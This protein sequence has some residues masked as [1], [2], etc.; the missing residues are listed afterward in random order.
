MIRPVLLRFCALSL[1]LSFV[2]LTASPVPAAGNAAGNAAAPE[3]QKKI[4]NAETFT[5][6]NGLQVVVIPNHRA[7]VVAHMVWYK[8]GAIDEDP[9]Q[10]G[11]AHFVE[12]LMFKGTQKTP[13]GDFSK[14]VRAMGGQDNAFTAEDYTAYHEVIA[15]QNLETIMEME[16]DR[17]A[18]LTF[19]P[20]DV[21]SERKVVIEER[22]ERTDNDPRGYFHEQLRAALFINHPYGSPVIGWLHEVDVLDRD[23]VKAFYETHYAPN[24][25]LLIVSGDITAAELR[26]LAEKIYGPVPAKNLPARHW[27]ET[28]PLPGLATLTLHHPSIHQP[29]LQ[30]LY[31]APSYGQNKQDSLALEVLQNIMDGGATSRLYKTLVVEKK[32]ATSAGMSYDGTNLSDGTLSFALT[33]ADNVSLDQLDHAVDEILRILIRDGISDQELRESKDRMKD[34]ATYAR[35]SLM[36]PAMIFGQALTTGAAIDDV[37]YWPAHIESVTA[38]QIQDVAKRYL[39]PDDYG[40]RPYVSGRLLPAETPAQEPGSPAGKATP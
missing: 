27:T 23:H 16:A 32:L 39:N 38:A 4:F 15:R 5:L 3:E 40:M 35:D 9:S 22:R 20:D 7:P 24:N 18:N 31:R 37:E 8:T 11:I 10:S 1:L 28:P 26:P 12:H 17:M 19:P 21:L 25:A 36:G 14:T 6:A 2:L 33:P 30:R 13:P 29:I 34:S